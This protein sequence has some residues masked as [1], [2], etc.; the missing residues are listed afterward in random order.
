MFLGF[1]LVSEKQKKSISLIFYSRS[2]YQ[3]IKRGH[4]F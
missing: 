1:I 3:H 4:L 2:H